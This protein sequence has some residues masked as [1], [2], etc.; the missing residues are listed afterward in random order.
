MVESV[1]AVSELYSPVS[2]T[3]IEV[4]DSLVDSPEIINDEPYGEAWMLKIELSNTSELEELLTAEEYKKYV[5]EE[6]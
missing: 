2:G 1:K 4:H 3:I 6:K 5:E